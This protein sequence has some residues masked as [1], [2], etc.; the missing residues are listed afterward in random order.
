MLHCIAC[1]SGLVYPAQY[2]GPT[3]VRAPDGTQE[4]VTD[5]LWHCEG[6][7]ANEQEVDDDGHEW[8]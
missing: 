6:C 3:G 5:H 2:H 8:D 7:G 1:G 4:I